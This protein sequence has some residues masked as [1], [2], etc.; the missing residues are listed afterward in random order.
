MSA[1]HDGPERHGAHPGG[2][3]PD[4]TPPRT[5]PGDRNHNRPRP[6]G[7]DT[8]P[9]DD[10]RTGTEGSDDRHRHDGDRYA[11]SGDQDEDADR[12]RCKGSDYRNRC[13]DRSDR[14]GAGGRDDRAGG[15]GGGGRDGDGGRGEQGLGFGRGESG[16][17]GDAL[18]AVLLG[19]P[20]SEAQRADPGFLDEYRAAAADVALLRAQLGIVGDALA[21]PPPAQVRA[22]PAGRR[23][24]LRHPGVRALGLAGALAAAFASAVFG[25]GWLAAHGGSGATS[26]GAA[27]GDQAAGT[28]PGPAGSPEHT[29]GAGYLACARLVVEGT[30]TAV[31]GIPHSGGER[32]TLRVTRAYKPATT[33]GEV[34]F[35]LAPGTGTRIRP[36]VRLLVGISAGQ[37]V[38]DRY[39]VGE[40]QIAPERARILR[41]LPASRTLSCD[42]SR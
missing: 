27:A 17:E 19:E 4:D 42:R 20:L 38:P 22:R 14:A 8:R 10:A 26:N 18:S 37:Q 11:A 33:A 3:V 30:V 24:P 32:V 31:H 7:P 25:I 5:R 29:T 21:G 16:V 34:E 28:A 9:R 40:A 1:E 13:D 15:D 41:D 35:P 23:R 39:A 36:G 6:T 12:A 2:D